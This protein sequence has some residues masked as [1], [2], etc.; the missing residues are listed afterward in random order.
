VSG[1]YPNLRRF[2]RGYVL[3]QWGWYVAGASA[4]LVTNWL[5]VQIPGLLAVGL[6]ALRAGEG[7]AASRAA[8]TIG[9]LGLGVIL[10]RTASR[11]WFFTPARNA[12]FN[13]REDMFAH[14]LRLQ[15]EFYARFTT[16]DLLSRTTSDVTFARAFAGFA[17]L[18]GFNVVAALSMAVGQMLVL[19]PGL[20]LA[21]AAPIL[22]G[23]LIVQA[24]TGPL[25]R[26]QRETQQRIGQFSDSLLGTIQGVGTIQG[27]N[28]ESAFEARLDAEASELRGLNLRMALL[29][30]LVFPLFGV[31]AGVAIFLLI[32]IGGGMALD[33][34]LTPGGLAA[35]VALV[36]YVLAPLRAVGWL[37]PVFQRAE[38]SLE[39]LHAVLD[40]PVD[41]PERGRAQPFPTPTRGPTLT[42]RNLS[43][44]FPDAPERPVLREVDVTIPG[45]SA[46]GVYGRTGSGKTTLLR[47]L[48]RLRNPPRGTVFVE[49]VDLLDLDLD[50]L[51]RRLVVVPQQVFLFS[52][53]IRE[54]VGL[55]LP[56]ERVEEA[57]RAA[58]LAPDL[59]ALPE[60]MS[61]VV[62]ERGIVLSGGQR[63]RVALARG[64]AREGQIVLL[65]DVL[66]AVDHTTEQELIRTLRARFA[67]GATTLLVSHRMS[68]LEHC[69]RVLVIEDGR[70][71]DQGTHAELV[72]R[73]GPYRDAWLAQTAEAAS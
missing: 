42:L 17:L 6:D 21:C 55:G 43:Y 40:A 19:S 38:A 41:R 48:A 29:R 23:Y 69:D 66:S 13:L 34:G 11:A 44:A 14:C 68:A 67:R 33:G 31:A 50:E 24:A 61:T 4:V 30:A 25:M 27:Y 9:L 65:D 28:V 3:P 45:G 10:V 49:G 39:R 2:S 52:E 37:V 36:A 1:W 32:W 7:E 26:L 53:T 72:A 8:W 58:S 64:L 12:E 70:L 15:P 63:Q 46:V 60:G 62:G 57:V 73:P 47:L 5:S 18:Q 16:G 20:T 51:R 56:G 35:F 54:N 59:A 71:V 22:A